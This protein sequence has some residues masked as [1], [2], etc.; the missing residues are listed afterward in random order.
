M[1][2]AL[3]GASGFVGKA[4]LPLLIAAGHEVSALYRKS[5]TADFDGVRV[6]LGDLTDQRALQ[7][8]TMGADVVLHI[9][10]AVSAKNAA[11][12]HS[13]NTDGT[14]AVAHAAIAGGVKRFVYLSSM[15]VQKPTISAYAASK[16]AAEEALKKLGREIDV[17]I[18]RPSAVY[19]PRDLATLPLLKQLLAPVA[20]LP[21]R[22][23]GRFALVHVEDLAAVCVSAVETDVTGLREIDDLSG[24]YGWSDLINVTRAAFNRPRLAITVPYGVAM[25]IGLVSSA[26]ARL[27]GTTAMLTVEKVREMYYPT[28]LTREE[29][30]QR[31]NP[32]QLAKGLPDTVRWYQAQG[33]LPLTKH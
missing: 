21:G 14:V 11:A 26:F 29:N 9:A 31:A 23:T 28:W 20:L 6:V 16:H 1:R 8:L 10:G 22:S 19:G 15:V 4:V 30:W 2:V 3:T 33:L 5:P 13:V 12:F 24:G 25:A 32:V 17:L 18:L 27:T 7:E